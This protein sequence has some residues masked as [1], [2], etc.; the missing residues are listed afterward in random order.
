MISLDF[1]TV[2]I[3]LGSAIDY[4]EMY[5]KEVKSFLNEC[6]QSKV[7]QLHNEF[8]QLGEKEFYIVCSSLLTAK[9]MLSIQPEILKMD[10]KLDTD[11]VEL[12][13]KS[14][15]KM[16]DDILANYVAAHQINVIE[17]VPMAIRSA[18]EDSII[19]IQG[20]LTPIQADEGEN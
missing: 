7:D 12:Q 19:H 9:V 13:C 20:I 17:W 6:T 11:Y 1:K 4:P 5:A 14:F 18:E 10:P 16:G 3:A 15:D 8:E 2:E